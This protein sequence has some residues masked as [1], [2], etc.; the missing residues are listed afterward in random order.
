GDRTS[1]GRMNTSA[2]NSWNEWDQLEEVVVGVVDGAVFPSWNV[3]N[4]ATVPP[5]NWDDIEAMIGSGGV[6]YPD[7]LIEG[8]NRCLDELL[9]ILKHASVKVTRPEPMAFDHCYSTPS[10]NVRT[11]F[12]AANPRDVFLV[13]GDEMIEAPMPDRGR[14]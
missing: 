9:E 13:V 8:A 4:K 3:I 14:Q 7:E 10:W 11:G 12:C 5:G 6:P 1:G 2:V